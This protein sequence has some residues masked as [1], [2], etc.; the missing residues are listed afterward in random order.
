MSRARD[1][2][3][4]NPYHQWLTNRGYAVLNVNFRGS[5]GFGKDFLNAGNREWYAKM[6]DDVNDVAQWAVDQGWA[7][8]WS[9]AHWATS[10]TSSCILAYHSRL[11]AFRKSLPKPVE[12]RKFTFKTA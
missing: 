1:N 8:P 7:H 2:W 12:P 9:T 6:Q 3:G 11:P 4:Y 5:T 10:F